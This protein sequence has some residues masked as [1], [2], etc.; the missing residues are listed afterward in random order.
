MDPV[1]PK[2]LEPFNVK[3]HHFTPNGFVQLSKFIWAVWTF[4]GVVLVDAFCKLFLFHCQSRKVYV[5][6][7]TEPRE[8]QNGCCTLVPRKAN[9]KVGLEKIMISLA[10]KNK[11]E[12]N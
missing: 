6:S 8:V 11:W 12:G 1:I 2:L 3:L 5:D 9:K 7:D 4:G 10:Q